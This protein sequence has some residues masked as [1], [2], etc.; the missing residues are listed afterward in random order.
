MNVAELEK[1][2][3]RISLIDDD[4]DIRAPRGIVTACILGEIK[5]HK[6]EIIH[7]LRLSD[8]Q[9]RA[10]RVNSLTELF[11]VLKDFSQHDW[12]ICQQSDISA[13]YT[14]H[15]LNLIEIEQANKWLTLQELACH[16]WSHQI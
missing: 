1:L 8:Y 2:N 11:A 7:T 12:N 13:A 4:L 6:R 9:Q 10:N 16:C 14:S 3:I 5:Q 15:A